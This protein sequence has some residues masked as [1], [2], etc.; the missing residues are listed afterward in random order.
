MTPHGQ[1]DNQKLLLTYLERQSKVI[2]KLSPRACRYLTSKNIHA[3][4]VA[5]RRAEA[6]FWILKQSD[7][8]LHFKKL[9]RDLHELE[10]SLGRVRELDVAM[11]DAD[12]YGIKSGRLKDQRKIARRKLLKL[13]KSAPRKK[14]AERFFSA[15]KI[16][17]TMSPQGM[18]DVKGKLREKIAHELKKPVYAENSLHKL[19]VTMKKVRYV[20]EC[21][22]KPVAPIKELQEVL[23]EAHDLET[24]QAFT[25]KNAKIKAA[26]VALN[27]R[28][29]RLIKPTLRFAENQLG[30]Q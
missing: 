2:S 21:M 6:V 4:R 29:I 16:V 12:N 9:R 20:L 1:T 10:K 5:T 7:S 22:G 27:E 15:Q 3:F 23:G 11:S 8:S 17:F 25:G 18:D 24:L 28:A 14:L 13:V 19:R 30:E 26:Q